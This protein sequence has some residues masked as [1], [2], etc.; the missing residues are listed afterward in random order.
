[1]NF[2]KKASFLIIE[3][4][5][6]KEKKFRQK[7]KKKS[8]C[9]TY[10]I[11]PVKKKIM[12]DITNIIHNIEYRVKEQEL[13]KAIKTVE[14]NISG[15]ENLTKRQIALAKRYNET[16]VQDEKTRTRITSL[17]NRNSTA[18]NNHKKSLEDNLINNKSLNKAMQQELG[19]IGAVEKKLSILKRARQTATS[20]Q[21]IARYNNLIAQ[22]Q[23][24][25]NK[26]QA[27]NIPTQN[28]PKGVGGL[29]NALVGQVGRLIP[30][31][32]GALALGGVALQIKEVTQQFE[33][34]RTVLR[35]TFQSSTKANQEFEKIKDFAK[36]T[37]YSVDE[38][39]GSFVKLVNRGFNPTKEEL[40]NMGDIAASQGK[41]FDQ[42]TE[43]VL[44]AQTG[45]FERLKEFGIKA[46]T[47]G[48]IVTL[49]FK[50]VEKQV[51]KTD[52]GA[53]RNAIISFGQLQG[54]AGGM[55]AQSQTLEGKLSN[56]GDSFDS[57]FS[58]IGGK[59]IG[60]FGALIDVVKEAVD[61]LNEFVEVSPVD[62]LREQQGELNNLVS[63]LILVNNEE[64]LRSEVMA[65]I[66]AKYPEFLSFINSEKTSVESLS[67]ALGIL[68]QQYEHKIR[69][70]SIDDG[71]AEKSEKQK[72]LF[73]E[74][75]EALNKLI[76]ALKEYGYTEVEFSKLS[77][78]E[79]QRV[80][81]EALSQLAE[82]KAKQANERIRTST[83]ESAGMYEVSQVESIVDARED[84]NNYFKLSDQLTSERNKLLELRNAK[85]ESYRNGLKETLKIEEE[86]LQ[87]L[88]K[89]GAS[90]QKIAE[91][92]GIINGIN[93]LLNPVTTKPQS[94]TPDTGKSKKKQKTAQE[95]ALEDIDKRQKIEEEKQKQAYERQMSQLKKAL[96]EK[97]I[98]QNYY[99]H[100]EQEY[101]ETN[102]I[103]LLKIEKKYDS[104]RLKYLKEAE[105]EA[106]KTKIANIDNSVKDIQ[107][108]LRSRSEQLLKEAIDNAKKLDEEL[109]NLLAS[110]EQREI[111]A[112]N[113]KFADSKSQ[114]SGTKTFDELLI[115]DADLIG[116]EKDGDS[117]RI[118]T[119]KKRIDQLKQILKKETQLT[120]Q[121][122]IERQT[123]ILE[124]QDKYFEKRELEATKRAI[125]ALNEYNYYEQQKFDTKFNQTDDE[126][127]N[128]VQAENDIKLEQL[129]NANAEI[130][131]EETL[132]NRKRLKLEE[133]RAKNSEEIARR[134][135]LAI[136]FIEKDGIE[137]SIANKQE[138]LKKIQSGELQV[139]E[140][141]KDK[142]EKELSDL[143]ANLGLTQKQIEELFA[144]LGKSS[145]KGLSD[146]TSAIFSLTDAM[147][148]A[149]SSIVSALESIAD[150]EI[151][152]RERRVEK[153]N[154]I[155]DRGNAEALQIEE[156]KL[157]KA[158]AQKEKYARIQMAI[159]LAQQA[160]ALALAIA[161]AAAAGGGWASAAAIASV[162]TAVGSG[163]ATVM[164]MTAD[165]PQGFKEGVIALN[166]K[167]SETSDSIPA[168]LSRG[169]SVI[170]AKGTKI[171]DNSKILEAMNNG[172]AFST[173]A[174][175]LKSPQIPSIVNNSNIKAE[176]SDIRKG[177]ENVVQA[178]ENIK[179]SK[180]IFDENG[181]A[182]ITNVI[183]EKKRRR[184]KL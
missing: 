27:Q 136:Q 16:A 23:A 85:E 55:E 115:A 5:K 37:P 35:N 49:S 11:Y 135:Q 158:Q 151:E 103:E 39:T 131:D 176:M 152:V 184:D 9:L 157:Q 13:Q 179:P 52:E 53:L 165:Q 31:I 36:D 128:V 51:K 140:A 166:G 144:Q 54:V 56:L 14:K 117:E 33:K 95:L 181:I 43:A 170:T 50:G 7:K 75:R 177:L 111:D 93:L 28:I 17:I 109:S 146:A 118:E 178:V 18:L 1:M 149:S 57:L 42:L 182:V 15:V 173:T 154:E 38:L 46:K 10:L 183:E 86:Q 21:E 67:E 167:G 66:S 87:L 47:T 147:L 119:A 142:I 68:N 163:I 12:E 58:N 78:K 148:S 82:K 180:M 79:Q 96:E 34:Y 105:K 91:Q 45:E 160:S 155:A 175:S 2:E 65:E 63:Q 77:R 104:E 32:G 110:E 83:R 19:L 134:T 64:E 102:K 162:I 174:M 122:E 138:E 137:K 126:G 80:G 8:N 20:P 127:V 97:L 89:Q 48:D 112:V 4:K 73:T 172:V 164:Q 133:E 161:Q 153:A 101:T 99:N 92:Q 29:P 125:S 61:W 159:N 71:L 156:E 81:T 171:G 84:F 116:A 130:I 123:A 44:D 106:T 88:I 100:V 41:S 121:E 124:I 107:L 26:P 143:L 120:E 168:M 132:S 113:K 22:Q 90:K 76:P 145:E 114:L 94:T 60:A 169:E 108:A 70:A 150:K 141:Y 24:K 98:D 3:I 40:T 6:K 129:K 69:L 30:A 25:I 74:Q 72:K 59:G 139:T 62:A